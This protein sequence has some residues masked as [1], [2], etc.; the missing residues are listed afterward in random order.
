M[1]AESPLKNGVKSVL[2]QLSSAT[3]AVLMQQPAELLK[4]VD[5]LRV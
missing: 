3:S 4:N 1:E 5:R 2:E